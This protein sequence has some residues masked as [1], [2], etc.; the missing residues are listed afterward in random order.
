MTD[1]GR[2]AP[3]SHADSLVTG[4]RRQFPRIS[5]QDFHS[6]AVS[7]I[8]SGSYYN[9]KTVQKRYA[10]P[11]SRELRGIPPSLISE[12]KEMFKTL[13]RVR[14]PSSGC[15]VEFPNVYGLKQHYQR[16]QGAPPLSRIV[17]SC[18]HCEAVFASRPQLQKHLMW[19]HSEKEESRENR[20]SPHVVSNGAKEKCKGV[21]KKG[22]TT[23]KVSKSVTVKTPGENGD[24]T[25]AKD[26]GKQADICLSDEDPER[27]RHR[28]KQKTPKKFTGEQPSITTTFGLKGLGKTEDKSRGRQGRIVQGRIEEQK[29]KIE[30]ARL[31]IIM[32][33]P[34]GSVD[35]KCHRLN[36]KKGEVTCPNCS[37]VTR[38]TMA[39]L[40]KHM[41]VCEQLQEALRCQQ[42]RKQFKSKAGL[43]YHTM[44]EHVNKSSISNG[45]PLDDPR[46]RERLRKMLKQMG[47]LRCPKQNCSAT[48]SSLMG[49]QYHTQRCGKQQC[50]REKLHF[51]CLQCNKTYQS[52]AGRDYH[53]RSEHCADSEE[54][55]P[56]SKQMEVVED[57]ERTPSGRVRRHSA[58]VAVFH[59]Q[60]I[61]EDELAKEGSRRRMKEDL[62]PDSR[63]LNYLR[64]GLPTFNPQ[65][66]DR[67]KALVKEN[68]FICCPNNCC[69][70]I[71][72]SVSGLKAHLANCNKGNHSGGKYRCLLCQK[73]FNSE[74]GV[75]YHILK[76]HS[77][78]WF[79]VS[80][81]SSPSKRK[82]SPECSTDV[83]E[84]KAIDKNKKMKFE[85]KASSHPTASRPPP[86]KVTSV[87]LKTQPRKAPSKPAAYMGKFRKV[88]L[89]EQGN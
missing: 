3:G 86:T 7:C 18:T 66:L 85:E 21:M 9:K 54:Q 76:T 83:S 4:S 11:E 78:N 81:V 12:W 59:L 25:Y 44:A 48:F 40:R 36:N 73:E 41:D 38:K 89:P 57:F 35:D 27:M 10:R 71:Y 63:R 20:P 33:S 42:C 47:R 6:A 29:K 70:A 17:L 39:G 15:W 56:K 60:E 61:A 8:D 53:M 51:S 32:K 55:E 13:S 88:F 87:A 24:I 75:K 58:Q 19:N 67:W 26:N 34:S 80:N 23:N 69:E 31:E 30:S 45:N 5:N 64:P 28:R 65:L 77:Q 14:C 46:G 50:D 52:K 16:C 1:I 68:G 82:R 43:N 72:S 2:R 49:Y 74:S 22:S 37:S 62:V 79:R 84:I